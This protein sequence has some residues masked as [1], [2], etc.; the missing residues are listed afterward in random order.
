MGHKKYTVGVV[1]II[2]YEKKILL[3]YPSYQYCWCLPGGF[4][5]NNE[6]AREALKREIKE[7]LNLEIMIK[8]MLDVV[9]DHKRRATNI[10]FLCEIESVQAVKINNEIDRFGFFDINNLPK[11]FFWLHSQLLRGLKIA[12]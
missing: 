5:E 8:E 6:T 10:V 11:D 7:E 4:V 3:V 1:G 12:Y 2:Y 9:I